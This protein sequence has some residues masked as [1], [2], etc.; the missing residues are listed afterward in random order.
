[1][2]Q[3]SH[4]RGPRRGGERER[5]RGPQ[6]IYEEIIAENFSNM[7]KEKVNQAQ[8]AQRVP[9]KI[10]PRRTTHSNQTDRNYRRR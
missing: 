9:G 6:N 8:E 3:P 2:Q 10:N 4:Y 1:M 5:E 7:G